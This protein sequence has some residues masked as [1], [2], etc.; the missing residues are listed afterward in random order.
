LWYSR[1][2]EDKLKNGDVFLTYLVSYPTFR[3]FMEFLRLDN[4]YV[5]GINANQTLMIVVAAAALG[6]LI[7]RH[8]KG[9]A[10]QDIAVEELE[11]TLTTEDDE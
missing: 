2:F 1:K 7:W 9:A 3:F 11:N 5:G 4:S 10:I 6:A 8:K